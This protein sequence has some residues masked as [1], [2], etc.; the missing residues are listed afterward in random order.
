MADFIDVTTFEGS[1]E[2]NGDDLSP[3]QVRC[4]F[5]GSKLF[6]ARRDEEKVTFDLKNV[7]DVKIL[8]GR[9]VALYFI[10]NSLKLSKVN[11]KGVIFFL[12]C[13][14]LT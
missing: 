2:T 10:S 6:C 7:V 1:Y 14:S 9:E 11:F 4:S 8:K 3:T 12:F 5:H 13:N